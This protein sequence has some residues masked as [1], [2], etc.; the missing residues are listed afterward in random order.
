[1]KAENTEEEPA[2]LSV[3]LGTVKKKKR[4]L[5]ARKKMQFCLNCLSC[6]WQNQC[7]KHT[8]IDGWAL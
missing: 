8:E 6:Q 5:E 1:M 4:F 3:G 7:D 2:A